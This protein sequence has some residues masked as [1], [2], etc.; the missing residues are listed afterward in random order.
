MTSG[1]L[2]KY[3][4]GLRIARSYGTL[5]LGSS[6]FTLTMPPRLLNEAGI[7]FARPTLKQQLHVE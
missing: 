4:K 5:R 3:R 6:G 1:E 7:F 2:L